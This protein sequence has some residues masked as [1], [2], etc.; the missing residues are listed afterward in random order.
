M[1]VS[2]PP[3][4]LAGDEHV[5]RHVDEPAQRAVQQRHLDVLAVSG[6][7]AAAQGGEDRDHRVQGREHVDDRD[8]DLRRRP[9]TSP[10]ML[11]SPDSAWMTKS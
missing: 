2:V 5:L 6:S 1:R 3:R 10:V 4:L 7:V 9:S 11:I 8:P